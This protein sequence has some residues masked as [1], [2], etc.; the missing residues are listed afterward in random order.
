VRV[1]HH[2]A[3]EAQQQ[4]GTV[5][6]GLR[7][8]LGADVAARAGAARR[9]P[10][11]RG[12]ER[13]AI[14]RAVVG[15]APGRERDDDVDRLGRPFLGGGGSVAQSASRTARTARIIFSWIVGWYRRIGL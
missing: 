11:G 1:D 15:H 2:R 7:D 14:T 5:G 12:A 6:R 8:R 13:S 10:A 9:S 4:Q 3:V